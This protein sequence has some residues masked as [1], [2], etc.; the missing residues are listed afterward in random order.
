[1]LG[2]LETIPKFETRDDLFVIKDIKMENYISTNKD[3]KLFIR[4]KGKNIS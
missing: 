2:I 4:N 1:M 3:T